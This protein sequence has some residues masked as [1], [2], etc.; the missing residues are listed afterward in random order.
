MYIVIIYS[1]LSVSSLFTCTGF[2]L[3]S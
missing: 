3:H 1:R 2:G